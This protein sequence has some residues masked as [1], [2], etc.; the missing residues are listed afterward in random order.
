MALTCFL[1]LDG[2]IVDFIG[3]LIEKFE[4]DRNLLINGEKYPLP[5]PLDYYVPEHNRHRIHTDWRIDDWISMQKLPWADELMSYLE[6]TFGRDNIYFCSSPGVPG[7]HWFDISA[8]GKGKWLSRH[9]PQY[10]ERLILT[11]NKESLASP[12]KLLIDDTESV[13]TSFIAGHGAAILFPNYWNTH[14]SI[15]LDHKDE[16]VYGPKAS[17]AVLRY[18]FPRIES[19]KRKGGCGCGG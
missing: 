15:L 10:T 8:V 16:G 13:F 17:A 2:V 1:D 18:V 7:T 19:F 14:Y 9:F 12:D 11:K 5:F 4:G 3:Y 6:F